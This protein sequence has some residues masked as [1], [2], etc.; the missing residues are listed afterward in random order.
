[1]WLVTIIFW[2]Q[3]FLCPFIIC[4]AIGFGI[5]KDLSIVSIVIGG[6]AGIV[7]AEYIRR[8]FG[9]DVFFGRLYGPNEMDEKLKKKD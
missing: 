2:L 6:V 8:K 9:L 4:V 1:M 5:T 7:F 3:A